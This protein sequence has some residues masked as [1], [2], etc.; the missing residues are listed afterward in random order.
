MEDV[1]FGRRYRVI[2]KIGSGGMADVFKA[3]DDVLGRTVAVKVLHARY[4]ADPT[5]VAR[6]RQEAQAAAN[7]SHP[8][9][10]NMYDWGRD[11]ETY[12]IVMEYVKGTDLKSLVSQQG[13]MDP[14]KAAEYAAQICSALAVAHG[15]DIIHRDIKPHNIVLT[16]DGTI[17]VMDFGIARAGNTTMTQTGSV[18]GTAQY[19]SPEQ[20]QGRQLSPASDLYSLGVTLYE[21]VTGRPPFDADTPVATALQQVNDEP[22]PPRQVRASI[23]PAL[24]AVILRAMRKNPAERYDSAAEMRDDLR[25]AANGDI[26][27][28]GVYA[29]AVDAGHTSVLP[30]VER[31]ASARPAGAPQIRPVPERRSSPWPWIA[32]V[33]AVLVVALGVAYALGVFGPGGIVVPTL[34]GLTEDEAQAELEAAGL[35]LGIVGVE[36]HDTVEPGLIISQDPAAGD[37]VEE[38][39]A[40]NIVVSQGIAQVAVPDLTEY[41]E[42]DAIAALRSTG[43]LAYDHTEDEHSSTVAKGLV[44]RTE[45][46]AGASVPKGT[47]V[48]LYVSLG[49]EQVTVPD[50]TGLTLAKAQAQLEDLGLKVTTTEAFNDTVA[51]GSVIS[52]KPDANVLLEAGRTIT[53]EISKGPEVIIVPDVRTMNEEDAKKALTDLGLEPKVVYVTSPDEGIVVNQF[54]IPGASAKRG[55]VIEIEVGKLPDGDGGGD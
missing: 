10:V 38:G 43:E 54:P 24:E 29:G 8:N 5:F 11:G 34:A 55:D 51:K 35:T 6:F 47:S 12:Y 49:V 39:T 37:E 25:R 17:K 9:I 18:L 36:N 52:Q 14:R 30:A 13:P 33:A 4:A 45:P 15:Y 19:I 50:V 53:L 26:P 41:I 20:A 40:V 42:A 32:L 31:A 1:V 2:E 46:A 28:G 3:V 16:P 22:M 7:L 23:P 44:I 21:M 48:I 27:S